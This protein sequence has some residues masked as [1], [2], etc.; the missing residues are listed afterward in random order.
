MRNTE[1]ECCDQPIYFSSLN[2]H[3]SMPLRAHQTCTHHPI[4]LFF[5]YF[6]RCIKICTFYQRETCWAGTRLEKARWGYASLSLAAALLA[7]VNG[8]PSKL[9][10]DGI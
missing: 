8:F 5:I 3:P 2:H 6:Q 4:D 9:G 1:L 7:D 10:K